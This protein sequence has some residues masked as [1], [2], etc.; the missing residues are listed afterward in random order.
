[1][2]RP[3]WKGLPQATAARRASK[4]SPP[5][6]VP[7]VW[8]PAGDKSAQDAA[9]RASQRVKVRPPEAVI[10]FSTFQAQTTARLPDPA[11]E[12]PETTNHARTA[13]RAT[14]VGEEAR[15]QAAAAARAARE[16]EDYTAA[17]AAIERAKPSA[18]PLQLARASLATSERH[19]KL[20]DQ[21]SRLRGPQREPPS[22]E[23]GQ[24]LLAALHGADENDAAYSAR[25]QPK[26]GSIPLTSALHP[27]NQMHQRPRTRPSSGAS[28]GRLKNDSGSGGGGGGGANELSVPV[29][30]GRPQ[31]RTRPQSSHVLSSGGHNPRTPWLGIG[32]DDANAD[33]YGREVA[34]AHEEPPAGEEE[35]AVV[36]APSDGDAQLQGL[37]AELERV[38]QLEAMLRSEK[39][40]RD[41]L[42]L[43]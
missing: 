32:F 20:R 42:E 33:P 6:I 5:A 1:M 17:K 25:L 4:V 37:Q 40:R 36:C 9:L 31:S 7:M 14:V 2:S 21:P 35:L 23:R 39:E 16:R 15:K 8:D 29:P 24:A 34:Y 27:V 41:E 28:S 13:A 19:R 43:S 18:Q 10:S 22:H 26:I 30:S 11:A 38:R 3:V 12:K